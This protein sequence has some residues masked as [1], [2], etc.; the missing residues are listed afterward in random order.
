MTIL[1]IISSKDSVNNVRCLPLGTSN[2]V[3]C[4]RTLSEPF[5]VDMF[6]T[7]IEKSTLGLLVGAISAISAI[8]AI[9]AIGAGWLGLRDVNRCDNVRHGAI[10]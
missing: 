7:T 3:D 8:G 4:G 2:L 1:A 9:G 6:S 10:V 5:R